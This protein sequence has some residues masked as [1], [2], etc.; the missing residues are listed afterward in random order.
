[1]FYDADSGLYLT[2][3]RAYDPLSGRWLSRD[4]IGEISS[5]PDSTISTVLF[6]AFRSARALDDSSF[7]TLSRL[8]YDPYS[9]PPAATAPLTDP[10]SININASYSVDNWVYLTQQ[11]AYVSSVARWISSDPGGEISIRGPN[12]Y[13]Y[14]YDNPIGLTDPTGEG[15]LGNLIRACGVVISLTVNDPTATSA[16]GNQR[17]PYGPPPIVQIVPSQ[18][19]KPK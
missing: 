5:I 3:Y 14:V 16:A 2:Q 18:G 13:W 12:L 15:T 4:P 17:G 8:G 19:P 7:G 9:S 1:M 11:G 10:V 6:G